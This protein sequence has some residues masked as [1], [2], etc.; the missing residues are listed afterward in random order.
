MSRLVA[1]LLAGAVAAAGPAAIA[2]EAPSRAEAILERIASTEGA[3]YQ[4]R[5]LVVSFGRPQAAAVLDVRSSPGGHFVRSESGGEV[6]RMWRRDGLG[7]VSEGRGWTSDPSPPVVELRPEAV[8]TKY[9][10]TVEGE[11]DVVGVPLIPLTLVRRSDRATVERLWVHDESGIVYRREL[12]D[13]EGTLVGMTAVLDMRWGRL[14]APDPVDA[15]PGEVEGVRSVRDAGAPAV[16]P[17]GYRLEGTYRIDDPDGRDV[18]HWVY[19]DGLHAL[20]VFSMPG[21]LKAPA[22]FLEHAGGLFVGPGPGTWAWEGAGRTWVLVA[23]EPGLDPALL[24]A[25]LP[26]GGHTI[27]ARLGSVWARL[28]SAIGALFG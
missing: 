25:P 7:V 27:W 11:Q 2:Q 1:L 19:A 6:A 21:G 22:G 20:S 9:D 18:S 5:Q 26:A 15:A 17:A 4:A 12:Y 14:A 8:I 24:R 16:L 28:F 3:T 10:V 23:E 13:P